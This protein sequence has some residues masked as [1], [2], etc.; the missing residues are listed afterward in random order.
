MTETSNGAHLRQS[1]KQRTA[2]IATGWNI[3]PRSIEM[4]GYVIEHGIHELVAMVD[5][6]KV[7]ISAA[8]EIAKLP[9]TKQSE[10]LAHGEQGI[11]IMVRCIRDEKELLRLR[12]K[13]A[14]LVRKHAQEDDGLAGFLRELADEI[15]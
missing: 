7:A 9:A 13:I 8:Y 5:A 10:I 2:A 11:R 3:S 1:R 12:D 4:A 15:E 14:R 6:S